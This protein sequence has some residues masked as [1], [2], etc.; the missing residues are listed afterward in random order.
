[1]ICWRPAAQD[2]DD[3]PFTDDATFPGRD[4][5]RRAT[6][7]LRREPQNAASAPRCNESPAI[8]G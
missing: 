5:V 8:F 6:R 3:M 7:T 1:M 4:T 2:D